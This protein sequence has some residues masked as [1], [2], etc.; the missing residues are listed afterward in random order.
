MT[1][2]LAGDLAGGYVNAGIGDNGSRVRQRNL[3]D[4]Q[5]VA[6]DIEAADAG[7]VA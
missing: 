7:V 2:G 6:G 5:G 1:L 3:R 4:S